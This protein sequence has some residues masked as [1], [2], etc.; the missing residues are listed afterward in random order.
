MISFIS[1]G[2]FMNDKLIRNIHKDDMKWLEENTPKG[3]SQ[4]QFLKSLIKDA[5]E[6]QEVFP[7]LRKQENQNKIFGKLPFKF[8][9]LFVGYWWL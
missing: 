3:L 2:E 1:G 5:R 9:D 8:I 6:K 4:N 7:F